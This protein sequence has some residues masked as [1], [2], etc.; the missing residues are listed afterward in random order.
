M[1]GYERMKAALELREP[2]RIPVME[3][4]IAENVMAAMVP[5]CRSEVDFAEAMDLDGVNM[6]R[7]PKPEDADPETGSYVN[8][9]GVVMQRTAEAYSPVG[10]PITSEA[11]FEAYVP[12]DPADE[13]NFRPLREAVKRYKGEKFISFHTRAEF[14]A[15]SE[16]RGLSDMLMD[17][18]DNP[19]F[20]HRVLKMVND[21]S[22]ERVRLGIEAGADA[23]VIAD[24]WAFNTGPF[25]SPEHFREFVL[26]YFKKMVQ[27]CK[28]GGAY[29]IKHCDGNMWPM[30]DMAVDAGIDAINPIEPVAGMDIGEVKE[31]YGKRVC[32]MGNIDC[33]NLLGRGSVDEVVRTVKETIAKAAPGGGYVLMSSNSIHSTVRPENLRAMWETTREFGRYPLDMAALR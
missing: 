27:T 29:A 9:W 13:E 14:M 4:A 16:V 7:W 26:P 19:E 6:R 3:W 30:L 1:N 11:A 8:E 5:G 17:F 23:V 21:V 2:D 25:M 24:D 28:D 15:A 18:V 10:P 31:K 20:A 22:C 33:G 12:P 32:L